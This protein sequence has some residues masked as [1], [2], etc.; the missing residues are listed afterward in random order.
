MNK[1][2]LKAELILH[3]SHFID[4]IR[5]L[6]KGQWE[7][8]RNGKWSPVQQLDHILRSVS[9]VKLAMSLPNFLLKL[10][11]GKVNRKSRK[12]DELIEKYHLKLKS[13]GRASSRFIPEKKTDSVE[14]ISDKLNRIINSLL[15]KI[16]SFTEDQLDQLI[17]PHPLLGKLTL[18][19]M[20]YFTI[21]HVQHHHQQI[22]TN[23]PT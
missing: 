16:D 18:R 8:S 1:N 5:S 10:V 11:F 19:E 21:Y 9:P 15:T 6:P 3:H 23:L 17:L 12:Y 4:T 20:L 13:G 7:V 2:E 14:V 22:K